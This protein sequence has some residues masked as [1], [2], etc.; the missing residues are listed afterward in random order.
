MVEVPEIGSDPE[1]Y[2]FHIDRAKYFES[3]NLSR[4]DFA[5]STYYK[6]DEKREKEKIKF[7][8]YNS[9]LSS[10]KMFA[11]LKKFE[12]KNINRITQLVNKTNQFNLTVKRFNLKELI[13]ISKDSKFITISGDLKDK[14]GDNGIVTLLIG[15]KEKK[16]LSIVLWV[17]SCRVF[18]RKLE[19]AIF[20][21][22]I[23]LCKRKGILTIYG[24]Y[25]KSKKNGIVKD[26]YKRLEF[27]KIKSKKNNDIW[28]FKINPKYFK[29]NKF[30]K[31]SSELKKKND[32]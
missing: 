2:I 19:L 1:K 27:K 12:K 31:I 29:K 32:K 30:I 9:Y 18:N 28:E 21:H 13:K 7:K 25:N 22:L 23:N 5:R 10:L 16:A 8:D 4:E 15:K 24:Y 3:F 20:D 14:F 11:E 6:M 17:M 26:F